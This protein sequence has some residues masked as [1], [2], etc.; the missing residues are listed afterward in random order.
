M[1]VTILEF[2]ALTKARMESQG[3]IE[4][5]HTTPDGGVCVYYRRPPTRQWVTVVNTHRMGRAARAKTNQSTRGSRRGSSSASSGTD[6]GDGDSDPE[7]PPGLSLW[8]H[9]RLGRCTP[10]LL[11]V[12]LRANRE[13]G[14]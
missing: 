8:R 6:P 12:L 2:L 14:R 10:N 3:H 13:E 11:R 1:Q 5:R 4:T 9:P 7:P